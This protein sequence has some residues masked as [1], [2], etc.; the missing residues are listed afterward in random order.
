MLEIVDVHLS[1]S[2]TN[3][4]R[5]LR[6]RSYDWITISNIAKDKSF[7][8]DLNTERGIVSMRVGFVL[9]STEIKPLFSD[10]CILIFMIRIHIQ[11]Y[12]TTVDGCGLARIV[13]NMQVFF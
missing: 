9:R 1:W 7:V 2:E 10:L 4:D 12:E 5:R 11:V 6:P 13:E 8:D 3:T